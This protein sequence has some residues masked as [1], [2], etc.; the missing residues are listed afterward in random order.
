MGL[1]F[2]SSAMEAEIL[3]VTELQDLLSSLTMANAKESALSL[4]PTDFARSVEDYRIFGQSIMTELRAH[5]QTSIA[6]VAELLRFLFTPTAE[7]TQFPRFAKTFLGDLMSGVYHLNFLGTHLLHFS[8]IRRLVDLSI[9]TDDDV[10]RMIRCVLVRS[11]L[12]QDHM[13]MLCMIF[14][15]EIEGRADD[16]WRTFSDMMNR[17]AVKSYR[18]PIRKLIDLWPSIKNDGWRLLREYLEYGYPLNSVQSIVKRDDLDGFKR[19]AQT[20][21]FDPNQPVGFSFFEGYF[22]LPND[23]SL[24]EYTAFCGSIRIFKFLLSAQATL[25]FATDFRQDFTKMSL[26]QFAIAGGH[27]EI[28]E[29]I[30]KKQCPFY[31]C[32]PVSVSFF[33]QDIFAWLFHNKSQELMNMQSKFG[34]V[35]HQ[36]ASS[37]NLRVLLFCIDQKCDINLRDGSNSTPLHLAIDYCRFTVAEVLLSHPLIKVNMKNQNSQTPLL[38]AA[39]HGLTCII[40]LLLRHSDVD[41]N[42][43]DKEGRTPLHRACELNHLESVKLLLRFPNID[44]NPRDGMRT[45]PLH[46]AAEK[47][48]PEILKVLLNLKPDVNC[49]DRTEST[50]LHKATNT[51]NTSCVRVLLDTKGID[52]NVQDMEGYTAL[53]HAARRSHGEVIR[54][55]LDTKGINVN[56]RCHKMGVVLPLSIPL[57]SGPWRTEISRS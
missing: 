42:I 24:I 4:L 48:F 55:L 1:S 30:A 32:L 47:G 51:S 27:L 46:I 18:T 36:S 10:V 19:L 54:E 12:Q 44:A 2:I 8:L 52:V 22:A 29:I 40:E 9:Y 43:K 34:T 23:P 11:E 57:C 26:E 6:P 31:S 7:N 21:G 33:R 3:R 20:P 50:P 37:G 35:L 15:P 53:H 25:V 38:L 14:G 45:T 28:I 16:L 41:S 49:R 17:S 5:P 56:A 13:I 39:M